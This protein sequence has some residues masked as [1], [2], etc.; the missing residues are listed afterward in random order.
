MISVSG[1]RGVFGTD[2]TPEN[3]AR[4]TAAWARF[5]RNRTNL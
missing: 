1:I 3:L 5:P 4:F 2:L